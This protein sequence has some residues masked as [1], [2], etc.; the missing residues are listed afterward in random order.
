MNFKIQKAIYSLLSEESFPHKVSNIEILETS[1]SWIILTGTYA[2]KIKKQ[3]DFEHIN[4]KSIE[5][6]LELCKEEIKINKRMSDDIYIGISAIVM[7]QGILK[8]YNVEDINNFNINESIL[9]VA[10]R[11]NQFNN[12]NLLSIKVQTGEINRECIIK[13]AQKIALFHFEATKLED[14]NPNKLINNAYNA[15]RYN[16]E[17][18]RRLEGENVD[19]IS[20]NNFSELYEKEDLYV[21]ETMQKRIRS[22]V[23]RDCHGD[24]HCENIFMKEN[25]ELEVFDSID[26][27]SNLRMIDPISDIAFLIMDLSARGAKKEAVDFLNSWLSETGDYNGMKLFRWYSIYRALVRAKVYAIRKLQSA[28]LKSKDKGIAIDNFNL[29]MNHAIKIRDQVRP[30]LIIMSG[31]S[32]SG[33]THLSNILS[34]Y[35]FAILIRSDVERKRAFNL[36]DIQLK[37]GYYNAQIEIKKHNKLFEGDLYSHQINEWLF[38]DHLPNITR[39]SLESGLATIVDATFLRK[40]ERNVMYEIAKEMKLPFAIINCYCC[41]KAARDRI[42][43]RKSLNNDDSDADIKTRQKQKSYKESFSIEEKRFEIKFSEDSS[44]QECLNR[45]KILFKEDWN[46]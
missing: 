26:F 5:R 17:I 39:S 40:K 31:L 27:D 3:L 11:M 30:K 2:Y 33:K 32:G 1:L 34:R 28:N 45:L 25:K 16:I 37:L 13:L 15:A 35:L 22:Q 4:T 29:Y 23:I 38:H 36:R 20:L 9:E 6:R 10:V 8:F 19:N 12:N 44:Y 24:L 43:K 21:V 42:T 14:E 7:N 18:I 46:C 41:E